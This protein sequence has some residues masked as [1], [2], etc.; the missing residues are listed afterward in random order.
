[1]DPEEL[2]FPARTLK[3]KSTISRRGVTDPISTGRL[4]CLRKGKYDTRQKEAS[5]DYGCVDKAAFVSRLEDS[6]RPATMP[7]G[8]QRF[9]KRGSFVGR[10]ASLTRESPKLRFE[11][12]K[13]IVATKGRIH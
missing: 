11:R 8:E 2:V 6:G 3:G 1:V 9:L 5:S 4:L 13:E 7:L 12:T 10:G